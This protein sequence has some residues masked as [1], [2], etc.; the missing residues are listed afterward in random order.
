MS[1]LPAWLHEPRDLS[2]LPL[3]L[4]RRLEEDWQLRQQGLCP[5][6]RT[7]GL[8]A[9]AALIHCLVNYDETAEGWDR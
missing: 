8:D 3:G 5:H 4:Q 9:G 2:R 7:A 1:A 6:C